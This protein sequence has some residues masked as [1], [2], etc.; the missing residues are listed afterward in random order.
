MGRLTGCC[1]CFD[2]RDGSRA[3]GIT[4]LVL[5]SL[6]LVSEVAGTIQL[7]QQENAQMNS[8]V[9]VQIVFQFVF[10][11]LHLV[12]NA[13]LVHGVNN[14]RRGMLLAWLIYTGIVTGL[15][16]IGVAIGFIAA[17]VTGVW[18]LILL[19]VAVAG[20]IAVFW[21]WFVVVL[22]YYQEMQEKNGFV[23]GKQANDAL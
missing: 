11:I 8:S 14:S 7:S 1:G 22:H 16:S 6:G 23:Y 4:L 19:V 17:C 20:L 9:I 5:G 12:M 3:I 13:L 18:W 10:C 21:Y 15:Q 2:L